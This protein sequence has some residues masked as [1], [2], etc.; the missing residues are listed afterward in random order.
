MNYYM[1]VALKN[2][3]FID[4]YSERNVNSMAVCNIGK[5]WSTDHK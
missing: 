4:K 2:R 5:M 1:T 3:R